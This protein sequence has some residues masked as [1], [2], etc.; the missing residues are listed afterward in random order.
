MNL[1]CIACH[2]GKAHL[3]KVNVYL[4]TRKRTDFFQQ[5]AFMGHARYMPHVEKTQAVMGHF[6]VDDENPGYDTKGDSMLRIKRFGGP[7]EPKFI[8]TD[9]KARQEEEPR[10]ALARMLTADPQFARATVNMFWAKLMGTGIVDPIDEFD[11]A[12]QDPNN[13]P[14]GWQ[15]QPTHPELLTDLARYFR[16]NNHSVHK[17]FSLICNSNA[18]Q[19]SARFP[20]EWSE[21]Y[22]PYYARKFARMLNAEELHD[23]IAIATGRPGKFGSSGGKKDPLQPQP[24]DPVG[25]AMQ[26]SVPRNSGEMKSFMQAFGQANR[27]T[28]ARPPQPSPLQPILMMRSPVVNDRVLSAKDSQVERLLGAYSD[29]GKVIDELF[30][31]TLSRQPLPE[32]R[33]LAV[34]ALERDRVQGAQNVQWALLNLVEFLY[35][36]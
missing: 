1:S 35:N 19:L 6:T 36:F 26:V 34:A 21:R 32:E 25:M 16:A 22:T 18:Y 20:G 4:S 17:L 30:V 13:L 3:E 9:E 33:L 31:A 7:A 29:N 23:S 15:A 27:G 24:A 14:E 28:P 5:S 2:D 10:D 8:L 11:L 12:R